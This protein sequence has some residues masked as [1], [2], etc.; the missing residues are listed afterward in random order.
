MND[1]EEK[2]TTQRLMIIVI[3][4]TICF[5]AMCASMVGGCRA[6]LAHD[7]ALVEKGFVETPNVGA[8]GTH[9]EKKQ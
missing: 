2:H 1:S 9:W 5:T 8:T 6:G 3:G 4:T 7:Q